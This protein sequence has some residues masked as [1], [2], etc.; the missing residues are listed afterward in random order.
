MS[1]TPTIL[2]EDNHLLVVEKPVNMPVQADASGD[3]DLLTAL[4]T[5]IKEKYSKPG[6]AYLGLVHRLDRPVGGVMVFAKTSKAAARLTSQFK[7]REAQKRYTAIVEGYPRPTAELN[8]WLCKDESTNTVSVV[9]EDAKGA[10]AAALRYTLLRQEGKLSLL[11][12]EPRTGRPHQIRVQLSHANLPILG[13]QRYNHYSET[14]SQIRLWAYSLTVKHPT[15]GETMSFFSMPKWKEFKTQLKYLPAYSVCCAVFENDEL[16]IVDKKSGVEVEEGLTA[17]LSAIESEL[18]TVHRLDANTEGLV[19]FAKNEAARD[20]LTEEFRERRVH[21]CYHAV[22]TGYMAGAGKLTDYALKD[23]KNATVRICDANTPGA[24]V[25]ETEFVCMN[26]RQNPDL[27]L[28]KL[29]PKTGRTH[30]LRVQLANVNHPIVGDDKYGNRTMNRELK[31]RRQLLLAKSIDI[32]GVF[33]E[34]CKEFDLDLF[35]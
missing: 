20:R 32:D 22:V 12:V 31:A 15:T 11:D 4:K 21:K 28:V 2:Y 8:D 3:R 35:G 10:K 18:Y 14:G 23:E 24:A 16:L 6:E 7:G 1:F 17:E 34:S 13:D 25:M 5:Y 33:A 27:T 19:V 9:T 29:L 30:Q 26:A